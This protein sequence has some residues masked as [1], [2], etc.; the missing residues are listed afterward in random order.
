[1]LVTIANTRAQTLSQVLGDIVESLL[2]A[3][4]VCDNFMA[5]G[6]ERMYQRLL[7]PFYDKHI[8]LRTLSHHPTKLLFELFQTQGCQNFEIIRENDIPGAKDGATSVRCD[9]KY[10]YRRTST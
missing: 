7:K 4:L 2:G 9:G 1:M 5:S 8:T 10:V 6:S 3:L